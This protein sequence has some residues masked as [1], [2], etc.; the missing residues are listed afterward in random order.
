MHHGCAHKYCRQL[1]VVSL[2]YLSHYGFII[3]LI[4]VGNSF[5]FN[6]KKK[7]ATRGLFNEETTSWSAP[8]GLGL[9][10]SPHASPCPG[11]LSPH[12]A[13]CQQ[14]LRKT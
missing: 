13:C 8:L 6:D 9:D 1:L 12:G 11:I 2:G 10:H 14:S 7:V 3:I 4:G 5:C